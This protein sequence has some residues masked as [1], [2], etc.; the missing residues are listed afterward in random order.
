M[1]PIPH[2]DLRSYY[3]EHGY[4]I[5]DTKLDTRKFKDIIDCLSP[6]FGHDGAVPEGVPFYDYNRIQD[7]WHLHKY[8]WEIANSKVVRKT[9]QHL[10]GKK[11][12]AFQTLNFKMGTHQPTHADTIHFNS[13]P[14]GAMCGVWVALEDIGPDQGPLRLYPGS[15]DLPEMNYPDFG[16]QADA[17]EY[18]KYLQG[19]EKLIEDNK[20]EERRATIKAGQ[21]VIWAANTLHGGSP[22]NN[23][24]LTRHS[25]VT[26]YYMGNPKAWRPSQS[27]D[28]RVFFTPDTVRNVHSLSHRL[29][30]YRVLLKQKLSRVLGVPQPT[31]K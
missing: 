5:I 22:Q 17:D 25:Q 30:F 2:S 8:V 26:H 14:F 31:G 20:Y 27:Q 13:E 16:L 9:L 7:A 6:Y 12:Q 23:L 10:Y 4:V 1:Q 11:P 21:A 15:N 28:E 24:E 29:G 18:P 19:V 3:A